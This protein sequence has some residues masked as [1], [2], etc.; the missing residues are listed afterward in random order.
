M[1]LRVVFQLPLAFE[2]GVVRLAGVPVAV[3]MC[4][5]HVPAAVRQ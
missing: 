3:S 4:L 2:A 1:E 5:Q